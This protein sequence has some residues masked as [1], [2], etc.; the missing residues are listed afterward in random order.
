MHQSENIVFTISPSFFHYIPVLR[1]EGACVCCCVGR[2]HVKR[3]HWMTIDW[4]AEG[5]LGQQ[6][7]TSNQHKCRHVHTHTHT[8]WRA[9]LACYPHPTRMPAVTW[10]ESRVRYEQG[11][12]EEEKELRGWAGGMEGSDTGWTTLGR[13]NLE[14]KNTDAVGCSGQFLYQPRHPWLDHDTDTSTES[15]ILLNSMLK[16]NQDQVYFSVC[17]HA[18]QMNL[19]QSF[20]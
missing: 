13:F 12:G 20:A 6:Y 3:K 11:G 4:A 10:V 19:I 7:G 16:R 1:G 9:G 2:P 5:K 15:I 14:G 18:T 17:S 8:A